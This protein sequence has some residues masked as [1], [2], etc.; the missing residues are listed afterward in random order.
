MNELAR[1]IIQRVL[2][3]HI[4]AL[5]EARGRGQADFVATF[6]SPP[7]THLVFEQN[8][9]LTALR[10]AH[11][12]FADVGAHGPLHAALVPLGANGDALAFWKERP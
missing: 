11:R 3:T 8:Q 4:E 10:Q 2:N 12:T 6:L 9:V 7:L 1:A 5:Q